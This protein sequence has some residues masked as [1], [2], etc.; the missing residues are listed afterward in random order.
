MRVIG[1]IEIVPHPFIEG[2]VDKDGN[3]VSA[4]KLRDGDRTIYVTPELFK[5]LRSEIRGPD[6]SGDVRSEHDPNPDT[7]DRGSE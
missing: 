1:A 4:V 6:L 2:M 3:P 5:R 7:A